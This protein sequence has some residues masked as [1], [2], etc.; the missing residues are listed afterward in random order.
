MHRDLPRLAKSELL[1]RLAEGHAARITVL[2]P[3]RRL[4][5]ALAREFDQA[6]VARGLATWETADIL[7]FGAFVER[8]WEDA[9]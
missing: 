9:L 7:S 6:Q 8:L 4:A 2:T 1:E 5:Q 3:N